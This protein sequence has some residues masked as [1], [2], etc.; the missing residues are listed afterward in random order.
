[1]SEDR[2]IQPVD[3]LYLRGN[4][5]FDGAGDYSEAQMP[6]LALNDVGRPA[7]TDSGR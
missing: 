3:V 2:F 5:L 7:R 1:M 6:P 4:R